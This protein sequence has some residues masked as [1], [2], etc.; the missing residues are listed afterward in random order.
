MT[1]D[2]NCVKCGL[3]KNKE[4]KS[5][6]MKYSG[7][8]RKKILIL[9]EAPGAVEDAKGTQL[10]GEAGQLL[11]DKLTDVNID[12]DFDCWKENAI[13]CR[14]PKNRTPS[15]KE[16][17][18]CRHRLAETI[19]KLKPD[20]IWVFGNVALEALLYDR[21]S[22]EAINISS[23]RG[24]CF[25]HK[26]SGAWVIPMFHPSYL[27]QRQD[28]LLTR[29]FENDLKYAVSCLK[30]KR[31]IF[32]DD[33]NKIMILKDHEDII[34]LLNTI[35]EEKPI[36]VYD[37]ETSGLKPYKSGHKIY[38]IGVSFIGCEQAYSFPFQHSYWTYEEYE[39]IEK[40][41]NRILRDKEIKK[42]AQNIKFEHIWTKVILGIDVESWHHDTMLATHILDS[43]RKITGLKIQAYLRWGVDDWAK[44][45]KKYIEE[46]E[47]GFNKLHLVELDK[48]LLYN[49]LDALYENKLYCEQTKELSRK[50]ELKKIYELFH[51]GILS[52]AD[53]EY[54]G[55]LVDKNYYDSVEK[56]IEKDIQE[57]YKKLANSDEAKKFET[58]IGRPVDI[59]KKD[60][61]K[62]ATKDLS[63][64]FYNVLGFKATKFTAKG[65]KPS[66]DEEA[67]SEFDSDFARDLLKLRKLFKIRNTYLAQMKREICDSKI[68]PSFD[69][70]IPETG[71]SSSS[72][73]NLHNIPKREDIARDIVRKGIIPS[74]NN[75]LLEVDYKTIEVRI[76]ACYT[77]DP[78]LIKYINDPTTDMHR[79][80]AMT[81]FMLDENQVTEP[82]RQ[83]GKNGFV[84]PEWYGDYYK[85]CA[86]SC[87]K[88][89]II[90]KTKDDILIKD[91]LSK[92]N[93]KSYVQFEEHM[94][95]VE[96]AFWDLFCVT[97]EWRDYEIDFY[98]RHG[99]VDSFFGFRRNGYLRRNQI[100]NAPIQ[101]SAFHCLLWSYIKLNRI[102]K[103]EGWK[104]KI[105][106]QVHDNIV[107]DLDLTEEKHIKAIVE[108]VMCK[109]IVEE[110]PWL[111]VP[112][113]VKMEESF[114]NGSWADVK[115]P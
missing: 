99:Y 58:I 50:K 86:K 74:L 19:K 110:H 30:R 60:D 77:H 113:E 71:R 103:E 33:E 27:L 16:I 91:H 81:I 12:L 76:M 114:A 102:R 54:D 112:L 70:H 66:I 55:I 56:E 17:N 108:K 4:L 6:F 44:E 93:V 82:I 100:C 87:W 42:I 37:Y 83:I 57:L 29:I 106:L 95:Q 21:F 13:C 3:Y 28:P 92:Y 67:L 23:W 85:A 40:L 62:I 105:I 32:S 38:T 1:L 47:E 8:G 52:F 7:E 97:K 34:E 75:K 73:P 79:D 53:T 80:Q 25:P 11:R 59:G 72:R 35:L 89:G 68:H 22:A 63:V 48:L 20:F 51:N 109:D 31:P 43:R 104:S 18:C 94:K 15:R 98:G 115:K 65:N 14:P 101:G 45:I 36:M 84:F 90:L 5:P 41:W 88:E 2:E 49:G 10:V 107:F 26:E 111:I 24:H 46:D 39:K 96:K 78:V 69:L 61:V 9:A 64:L